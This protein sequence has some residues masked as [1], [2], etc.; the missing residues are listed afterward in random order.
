MLLFRGRIWSC[1]RCRTGV[2]K[3]GEGAEGTSKSP[4]KVFWMTWRPDPWMLSRE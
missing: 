3:K 2:N 1:R 4:W